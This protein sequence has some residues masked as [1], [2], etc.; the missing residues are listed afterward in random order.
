MTASHRLLPAAVTFLVIFVAAGCAT[1]ASP[2]TDTLPNR[3]LD[4]F[5]HIEDPDG[6][7][8]EFIPEVSAED[9]KVNVRAMDYSLNEVFKGMTT[10]MLLTKFD[11]LN[12]ESSNHLTVAVD[13][14]HLQE[15]RLHGTINQIDMGVIVKLRR[16]D[17]TL[18]RSYTFT[19]GRN[20]EGYAIRSGQIQELL[21]EFVGEIDQFV[22]RG[23]RKMG[24]TAG[25]SVR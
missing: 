2:L 6:I 22:N 4:S 23:F 3:V 12:S 15:E 18:Q 16:G 8:L 14:I 19:T 25:K 17:D 7:A 10:E 13:Y 1:T 5:Q 20:L 24:A 21:L 11:T 9:I